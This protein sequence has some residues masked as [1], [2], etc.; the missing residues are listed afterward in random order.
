MPKWSPTMKYVITRGDDCGSNAT[1]DRGIMA[2]IREGVLRNVSLMAT[3]ATIEEAARQFADLQQVC[4][5]VHLTVNAEWDQVRWGPV[6]PADEVPSL[7]DEQGFFYHT[8]EQM[9]Q[10]G[11]KLDEV[12]IELDAQLAKLRS[13][14]FLVVYAD[15]HM[16]FG[17]VFPDYPER[18][19]QWCRSHG[20]VNH[21]WMPDRLPVVE[22][23]GMD[24]VE[25]LIA[26]LEAAPPGLYT[27]V[28]HPA[29]DT[30]EMRRLGH[31]GHPGEK[32]AMGRDWERRMFMDPRILKYVREQ[33]IRILRYDEA[34]KLDGSV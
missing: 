4:F 18:F 27:L 21:R 16:L 28:G 7:L 10:A 5:G 34:A 9:H 8:P 20:L 25:Q 31:A 6:A 3:G 32:V 15:E 14:G 23:A 19:D 2:A 24:R 1:A 26:Q 29:Y 13:L 12:F 30:D 17:R 33:D 11:A 22:P